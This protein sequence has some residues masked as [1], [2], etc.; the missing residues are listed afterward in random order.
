M[1]IDED[2]SDAEEMKRLI[3][4]SDDEEEQESEQE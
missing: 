4:Y 1:S 2:D 3:D